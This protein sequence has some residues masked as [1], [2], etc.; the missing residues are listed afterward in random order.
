[1][2]KKAGVNFNIGFLGLLA[3]LFIGLRLGG[4]IDWSWWI[5][6]LP[7]W[8]PL[9]LVG[10]LFFVLALVAGTGAIIAAISEKRRG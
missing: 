7:L 2:V 8:G 9:A 1:M 3:L 10:G 5:V 4:V 6:L